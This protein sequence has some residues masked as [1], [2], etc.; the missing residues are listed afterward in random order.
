[1]IFSKIKS[2]GNIYNFIWWNNSYTNFWRISLIKYVKH[3]IM[4][5][6][7]N[8]IYIIYTI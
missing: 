7:I 1:M 6:Q 2:T 3:H 4:S 8:K 5:I